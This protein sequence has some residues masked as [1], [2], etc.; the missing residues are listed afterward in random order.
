MKLIYK[1]LLILL[2]V[3]LTIFATEK[4]KYTRNKVINKEFKVSKNA[5]L[6][7]SNKYGNVNIITSNSNQIIIKVSITTNGNDEEKVEQR[8]D[9]IDVDFDASSSF[10]SAK[11]II[12]KNTS[13]W[14]WFGKRNSINMEI[15][16]QIQMPI[17]NNLEVSNDY[18][19]VNLDKIEG[20]TK[21]DVDYGKL[22]IGELLNSKNN[23]NIDYTNKSQIDFMKDGDINADYSTLHIERSGRTNLNADYS[24]ISFGMV[25]NLDFNCDY[26][27]LKIDNAGNAFGNT[28]YLS[29][30]I[31]KLSGSG[32]FDVDYGGI[33]ID[34]LGKNFKTLKVKAEYASVKVGIP[35]N[36]N[37]NIT[38]STSYG[39]FSYRDGFTFNKEIKEN[40]SKYYEGYYGTENSESSIHIKTSYGSISLKN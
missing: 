16:Y 21:F 35:D 29:I 8:L 34:D 10:V 40:T 19:G 33:H 4:G 37:F 38:A 24:N 30:K 1:T 3:P 2:F 31:N 32:D 5:T 25:T 22:N 28:D 17:T 23:I 36:A 20:T 13:Y 7:I 14:S 39:G 27:S 6:E 9:Q 12:E 15:N 18:G 26:G 11:T